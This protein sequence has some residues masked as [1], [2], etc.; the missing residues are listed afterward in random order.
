MPTPD[1]LDVSLHQLKFDSHDLS[2]K[3][4]YTAKEATTHELVQT[5][6]SK[7]D[8]LQ[9]EISELRTKVDP[10]HSTVIET[11]RHVIEEFKRLNSA[12]HL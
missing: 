4:L 1:Q 6:V 8:A 7:V 10:P 3:V 12:G 11:G 2:R 5:L 9:V